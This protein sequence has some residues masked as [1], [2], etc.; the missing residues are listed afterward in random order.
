MPP[1]DVFDARWIDDD[2]SGAGFGEGLLTDIRSGDTTL[3]GTRVHEVQVQPGAA[4]D[5]VT[6]SWA[7]PP[8]VTGTLTDVVTDGE[9]VNVPLEGS[10]SY[11]LTDLNITK[12]YVTL[13]YVMG[14]APPEASDDTYTTPENST[15]TVPPPGVLGN[16]TDAN[17][18]DLEASMVSG[19][20]NGTLT[21]SGNGSFTYDP[22][23]DFTGT[24]SF[25]YEAADGNGGTDQATA[26]IQVVE[27]DSVTVQLD[28]VVAAPGDTLTVPIQVGNLGAADS[29]LSYG[30]ELDF[31]EDVLEYIGFE[32]NGT[33]TEA[34]GF[35]V[36]ENPEIPRIG[37]FGADTPLNEVA[38]DGSGT[39]LK[40]KLAVTATD[41]STVTLD[42]LKFNS[43]EVPAS[44]AEPSFL[45][46]ATILPGDVSGDGHVSPFDASLA[47]Q[48]FLDLEDLTPR[49]QTAAD[50]SGDDRVTPFDASL[51]LQE[52]LGIRGS[53]AIAQVGGAASSTS[54]SSESLVRLG[55]PRVTDGRATVP[56]LLSGQADGVQSVALTL[57]TSSEKVSVEGAEANV[58][59]GWM[60]EHTLRED[61]TMQ[62]GLAGPRGTD[63]PRKI[64]TVTYRRAEADAALGVHGHARLNG[65]AKV[66]LERNVPTEVGLGRVYPNP[67][68]QSATVEYRLPESREVT[69]SVY[70][71]L[72]RKVA[73]PVE[74]KQPAG[75]HEAAVEASRLPSGTY[76][77]RLEAGRFSATRK[78]TVT[79]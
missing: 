12:L 32:T 51:I 67:V 68:R 14:N 19:P 18:E 37:G 74:G 23:T 49:Q 79:R 44:P 5:E 62:M 25:T 72:G 76:F 39:M 53:R 16:D 66:S 17:G 36:D 9:Q 65:G 28:D 63:G 27:G 54:N 22:A 15:L 58:P 45:V 77:L 29:V 30:F 70:D 56:V 20:S 43:G 8:G 57:E 52:F 10:G 1:S 75:R 24:D 61:G 55:A 11:T 7:L 6:F 35:T 47:L 34:A 73:T 46:D 48:F 13:E 3:V 78:M 50:L 21:L 41:S 38:E 59:E 42:S 4:A 31:D 2:V 71:V 69:V 40:L 60:A 33:L 64:A 26:E